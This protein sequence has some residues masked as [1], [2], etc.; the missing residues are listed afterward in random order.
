MKPRALNIADES[1]SE[2]STPET[3]MDSMPQTKAWEQFMGRRKVLLGFM[4]LNDYR[5]CSV[6]AADEL[7]EAFYGVT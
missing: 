3:A 5:R 2:L 4:R 7:R 6:R 1:T